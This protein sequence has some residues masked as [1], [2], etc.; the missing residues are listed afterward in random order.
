MPPAKSS[1]A[2]LIDL[3]IARAPALLAAG[4]TSLSVDGFTVTLSLPP[5]AAADVPAPAPPTQHI[6]P[7]QDPATFQGGKLPGFVRPAMPK[8]EE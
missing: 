3:I 7:M 4:V 1:P 6:D 8:Y 5:P 2:A